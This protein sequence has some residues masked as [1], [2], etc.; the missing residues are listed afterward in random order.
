MQALVMLADVH[1][2]GRWQIAR[3]QQELARAGVV[4]YR[5]VC[6]VVGGS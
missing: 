4:P 6:T 3:L 1:L 5:C 2:P